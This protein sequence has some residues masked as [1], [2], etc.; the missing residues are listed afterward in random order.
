[1]PTADADPHGGLD[2]WEELDEN[3]VCGPATTTRTTGT[4]SNNVPKKN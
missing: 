4:A 3:D 2:A 1:M